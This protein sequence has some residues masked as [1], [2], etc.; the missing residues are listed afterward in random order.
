M[1]KG[2]TALLVDTTFGFF[3]GAV[4]EL[5]ATG[6]RPVGLALTHHDLLSYGDAI[7]PIR[8][9]CSGPLLIHPLDAV[10]PMARRSGVEVGDIEDH[11][12]ML[13][14]GVEVIHF[15]GHTVGS[16]MLYRSADGLLLVGDSAMGAAEDA[17]PGALRLV[18]PPVCTS[19]DDEA[20]RRGW[21]TFDREVRQVGPLHG[22]MVTGDMHQLQADVAGLADP[23]SV[24]HVDGVPPPSVEDSATL[25]E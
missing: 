23:Q 5:V 20:L 2:G 12:L 25:H 22:S 16:V 6:L 4:Q 17:A 15:P 14:F 1:V 21:A 18:R 13:D 24:A 10:H 8:K 3:L 9:L 11:A 7:S 19:V